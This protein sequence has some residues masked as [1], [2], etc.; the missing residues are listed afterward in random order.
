MSANFEQSTGQQFSQSAGQN[1]GCGPVS[2]SIAFKAILFQNYFSS[3]SNFSDMVE[4][5]RTNQDA[6][7]AT[8]A[9]GETWY[10]NFQI[11]P[12]LD[13]GAGSMVGFGGNVDY[14][15]FERV[16]LWPF[17]SPATACYDDVAFNGASLSSTGSAGTSPSGQTFVGNARASWALLKGNAQVSNEYLELTNPAILTPLAS[18][19]N[20]NLNQVGPAVYDTLSYAVQTQYKILIP[21]KEDLRLTEVNQFALT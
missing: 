3:D 17:A 4:L 5:L 21:T 9:W 20:P 13:I 15:A 12:V 16:S 19:P 18:T 8:M 6:I 1:R 14:S 2:N 7:M 10:W 11:N